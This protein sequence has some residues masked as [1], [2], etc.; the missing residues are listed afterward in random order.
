ML[1]FLVELI[2]NE[3][4]DLLGIITD[5]TFVKA[6]KDM[7]FRD[8]D[9]GIANFQA[10]YTKATA[11]IDSYRTFPTLHA[12]RPSEQDHFIQVTKVSLQPSRLVLT[13]LGLFRTCSRM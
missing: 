8:I 6:A 1:T 12:D 5:L 10:S 3:F 4:P 13:A 2:K 9:E 7:K 11:L